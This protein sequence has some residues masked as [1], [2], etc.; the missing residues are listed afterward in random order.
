V[1]PVTAPS[2]LAMEIQRQ[3]QVVL[4]QI[5]QLQGAGLDPVAMLQAQ[6]LQLQ[7]LQQLQ[8]QQ[9]QLAGAVAGQAPQTPQ[10]LLSVMGLTQSAGRSQNA[11]AAADSKKKREVYVGSLPATTANVDNVREFFTVLLNRL[12]AYRAKYSQMGFSPILNVNF[13]GENGYAF[14][15][16]ADE[17]LAS[18]VVEFDRTEFGGRQLKVG[19][20]A[21]T[22][23]G[24]YFAPSLDV[25]PLRQSGLIPHVSPNMHAMPGFGS[26]PAADPLEKKRR[27][28]YVGNLTMGQVTPE[29]LRE[30]FTPACEILPDYDRSKGPPVVHVNL[31]EPG[32]FAFVEFQNEAIANQVISLFDNMDLLGRKMMCKRPNVVSA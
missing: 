32:K 21:K 12:P 9:A 8:V 11:S 13:G 27:E 31:P 10:Q 18:T 6:Q 7:Q 22:A 17:I 2:P 19:R 24:T 16:M 28:V 14:L 29:I 1:S 23:M 15:E 5:Q 25:T 26:T 3:Q 4:Q 20:P 30:L